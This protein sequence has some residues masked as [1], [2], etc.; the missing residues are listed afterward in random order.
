MSNPVQSFLFGDADTVTDDLATRELR[1]LAW[2]IQSP[3]LERARRQLAWLYDRQANVLVLTEVKTGEAAAH[4]AKDLDSNGYQIARPPHGPD[5]KYV[6]LIA[7]KGYRARPLA[8]AF[9]TPRLSGVRLDTHLGDVDVIA[10]YSLTNGMSAD[11]SRNRAAFQSEVLRALETRIR[12]EPDIP[13]L[14]TGD[15]N[16]LEPGHIPPCDLFEEH[17]YAFYR[18]LEGLGLFDAYR[19][20]QPDGTDVTWLGPKGG[21]RLDHGFAS[22]SLAGRG[23]LAA[24]GYDHR[25][26]TSG[27]SDH[28]AF[29]LTLGG[30]TQ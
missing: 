8:L 4:I 17:D 3:S 5:D 21:Q 1:L 12:D 7:T 9:T 14:L 18:A 30:I 20:L 29:T 26:R 11:S 19:A 27:L 25:A 16:V 22:P 2:N 24:C 15:F 13:L 28:S 23:Q 10:L 6:N